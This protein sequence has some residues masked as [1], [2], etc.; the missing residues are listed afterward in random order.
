MELIHKFSVDNMAYVLD[1]NTGSVMEIDEIVY[2]LLESEAVISI[3][4]AIEKYLSK[5]SENEIREA[6][7]E[8]QQLIDEGILY[9]KDMYEEKVTIN[10]AQEFVKAMCL[11]VVHD[12]NL[13]CKYCF[14]DEGEYR[15]KREIMTFDVAKKALDYLI[16]QSGPRYN[17]EVDLFGG[18]PLMAF[19][20]IKKLVE[21]AK[22]IEKDANKNIRFTMTTNGVLLNDE[23]IEYLNKNMKNIIL[24][25]DGRKEVN[26]NMRP[27]AIGTG[28]YDV[29]INKI[30]KLVNNREEG[31]EYYVRGTY[32][33]QN[34]DFSKDFEH[35]AEEGFKEISLE[36]V[37]IN[38][39]NEIAISFDDLELVYDEY[40]KIYKYLTQKVKA[41]E[42]INF[43]HYNINLTGGPCVYK[44]VSACGAGFEYI[45]ITP[46]G[47][48][49]PCHQFVGKTDFI[50]GNVNDIAMDK[51]K[52]KDLVEEFQAANIYNKEDCNKC[53]A[54]FYCS[55]GC[56]ANNHEFTNSILEPY[57]VGCALQKKRIEMA[58]AL[59]VFENSFDSK[60]T[61]K[62]SV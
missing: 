57:R 22:T 52:R 6:I 49:Y 41:G 17:I 5:Y 61:L 24:S 8:I 44:R 47:D 56:Q 25:I 32:T 58:I 29:I 51:I 34:L 27:T 13:K 23:I 35:L 7:S 15:G 36:P 9:T 46:S 59:K 48:I 43:Y 19:D 1:V 14:A 4:K 21:Y 3:E 2:D 31:Q 50:L 33:H 12:C 18:E 62:E 39:N 26:D 28:S 30:K 37:V 42:K 53:W 54:R 55:G 60:Q 11:N 40:D 45:A 16:S 38:G 20:M 10:N